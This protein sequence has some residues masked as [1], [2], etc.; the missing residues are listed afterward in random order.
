[1]AYVEAFIKRAGEEHRNFVLTHRWH[2]NRMSSFTYS[3]RVRGAALD[4]AR[5]RAGTTSGFEQLER[6]ATPVLRRRGITLLDDIRA[7]NASS[8]FAFYGLGWDMAKEEF[9]LYLMTDRLDALPQHFLRVFRESLEPISAM[10]LH[11]YSLLSVTYAVPRQDRD[12]RA[13][14]A[15]VE[16]KLYVYPE[17]MA[18][19]QRLGIQVEEQGGAVAGSVAVM[20]ST[21]RGY[22]A[23]F[24][25]DTSVS[26]RLRQGLNDVGRRVTDAY[27]D[28]GLFLETMT[29]EHP[30]SF[31]LYFPS[32]SG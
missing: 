16:E 3:H 26:C 6:L 28:V 21:E 5:F 24:D 10:A 15:V 8:A 12:G 20:L 18:D 29:Y 22:V 4:S 31:T 19:V 9:K 2:G 27:S 25:L 23:Q 30:D 13:V 14:S 7:S 17:R 11:P 32:G 1:M